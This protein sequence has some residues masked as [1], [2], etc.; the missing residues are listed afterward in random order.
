MRYN[1]KIKGFVISNIGQ[2]ELVNCY[3]ANYD[4]VGNYTL[5]LFNS[6]TAQVL[7]LSTVCVSP[8]LD[9]ETISNLYTPMHK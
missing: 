2:F 8:E 4:L 7:D 1:F 9:K 3:S 5:N 6:E